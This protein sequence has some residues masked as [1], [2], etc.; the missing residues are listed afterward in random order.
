MR[1]HKIQLGLEHIEIESGIKD[2]LATVRCLLASRSISKHLR[3]SVADELS[4]TTC[5]ETFLHPPSYIQINLAIFLNLLPVDLQSL[6]VPLIAFDERSLYSATCY[7]EIFPLVI[8]LT[9]C[10]R[11]GLA[12]S[13]DCHLQLCGGI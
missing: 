10:R 4:P 2:G 11:E 9:T 3:V 7:S 5:Y 8:D 12:T 13:K 1:H 6:T